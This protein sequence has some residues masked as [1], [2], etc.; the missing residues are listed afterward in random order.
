MKKVLFFVAALFLLASCNEPSDNKGNA[1]TGVTLTPTSMNLVQGESKRISSAITPAGATGKLI[2]S[3][4]DETIATV[5]D[6]GV[7]TAGSFTT[8]PVT[9]TCTVEGTE[10]ISA[11]CAVTVV[12]FYENLTWESV[13]LWDIEENYAPGEAAG[14]TIGLATLYMFSNGLFV[15]DNGYIDG[16]EGVRVKMFSP[17]RYDGTYIYVLG[18]Y[19]ISSNPYVEGSTTIMGQH[20]IL[21][22]SINEGIYLDYMEALLTEQQPNKD[23][24]PY[25]H[26]TDAQNLTA[27]EDGQ[28][29]YSMDCG[30]ITSGTFSVNKDP[31]GGYAWLFDYYNI[32]ATMFTDYYGLATEV[33][34]VDGEEGVYIKSPLEFSSENFNYVKEGTASA[35]IKMTRVEAAHQIR[36]NRAMNVALQT[37]MDTKK[38]YKK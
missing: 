23:D 8:G 34:E 36:V 10:N 1:A 20:Q 12:T 6:K 11:T 21:A 14:D 2:W 17:Y 29:Y 5:D 16:T 35:P 30:F 33:K 22:G 18:E 32:N 28:G 38:L 4:S 26:G 9:I 24:Y 27:A 31:N 19:N 13:A 25:M 37:K 3:T 15:N 7:V